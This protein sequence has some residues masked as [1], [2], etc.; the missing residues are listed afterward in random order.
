MNK[1]AS[2][3]LSVNAIVVLILAI[4][5]L[6]L[7]MAFIKGMFTDVQT[8]LEQQIGQES[9]PGAASAGEPITLSREHIMTTSGDT[10]IIK[11]NVFNPTNQKWTNVKTNI[12]C[13]AGASPSSLATSSIDKD[14]EINSYEQYITKLDVSGSI[15]TYLCKLNVFSAAHE[16][17]SKDLTIEITN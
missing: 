7:G 15:G 14:I 5:M 13:I 4:T 12:T 2:L 9:E 8:K 10:E 6:G 3:S 16:F 17:G 11:V 1:K